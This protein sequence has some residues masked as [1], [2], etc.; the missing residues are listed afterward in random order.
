[1]DNA[2]STILIVVVI[3]VVVFLILRE[4]N[5]W[6]WKINERVSLQKEQ[7]SILKKILKELNNEPKSKNKSTSQKKGDDYY[8]D[9]TF[10]E[11]EDEKTEDSLDEE[12]IYEIELTTDE[13]KQVDA[14]AKFGLNPGERLAINKTNRKIN[15]FDDIEWNKINQ[16]EW[17]ILMEN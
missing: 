14:F 12:V 10:V 4:V 13:Q 17:I 11:D 2:V 6:Y 5:C 15:R 8:V 9:K 7:N 3:L 16:S 1:M